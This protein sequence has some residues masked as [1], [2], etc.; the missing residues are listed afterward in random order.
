VDHVPLDLDPTTLVA[1]GIGALLSLRVLV[2]GLL[3]APTTM[4]GA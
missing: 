1:H 2:L 4:L 3:L